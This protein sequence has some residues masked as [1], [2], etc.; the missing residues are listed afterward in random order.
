MKTYVSIP[1][2]RISKQIV[3][4]NAYIIFATVPHFW[5]MAN[6]PKEV[7]IKFFGRNLRKFR[8]GKNLS[9]Q[10]LANIAEIEK[11][12]IA[13]IEIGKTNPRLATILIIAQALEIE[14]KE[15][16]NK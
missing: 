3:G 14:P 16:F 7:D 4:K 13:R 12:Q 10:E 6:S 8:E 11:S 9:M 2:L 1:K 15:F 5:L